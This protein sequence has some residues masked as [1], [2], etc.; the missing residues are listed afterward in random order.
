[1]ADIT[2]GLQRPGQKLATGDPMA[3]FLI[4]FGGLVLNAFEADNKFLGRHTL[5]TIQNG[6]GERFDALGEA[7]A[8][9]HVPGSDLSN[10]GQIIKHDAFDI[11]VDAKLISHL[12]LDEIEDAMNHFELKQRYSQ[13]LGRALANAMDANIARTAILA[14]RSP[15]R[16]PDGFGGT[17]ISNSL[18]GTDVEV[19]TKAIFDAAVA[20]DNK[21]VPEGGRYLFVQPQYY[22]MLAQNLN[23][24]NSLYNGMG[25]I[26]DGTML[27]VAGFD[28]VKSTTVPNTNVTNTYNNKYNGDFSST[29]GICM[30]EE[31]VGTVQLKGL[32]TEAEWIPLNQAWFLAAKFC[33]GHGILRPECAVELTTATPALSNTYDIDATQPLEITTGT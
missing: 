19:L 13:K 14:A 33:L 10:N 9:Y 32:A 18:M 21:R 23:L 20:M 27:R 7:G 26:A 3:M 24:I 28:V 6:R 17:V 1:M 30:T 15:S 29:I 4:E 2:T 8:V 11:L 5:R 12:L 31:A 25:S 22:S 16:V